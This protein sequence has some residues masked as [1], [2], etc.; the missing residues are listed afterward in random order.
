MGLGQY[1]SLGE[2]CDLHTASSVF[3]FLLIF[4]DRPETTIYGRWCCYCP[5]APSGVRCHYISVYFLL[6]T[7]VGSGCLQ[8][9]N[10]EVSPQIKPE[11]KIYN[12]HMKLIAGITLEARTH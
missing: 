4:P 2:Y 9:Y 10:F 8:M 1:D 6:P 5:S 7:T 11:N 3:L 12:M